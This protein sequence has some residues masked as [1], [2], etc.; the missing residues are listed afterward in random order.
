M[1]PIRIQRERKRG[2]RKPPNTTCVTRGTLWGNPFIVRPDLPVS[3]KVG[4]YFAVPTV[5]DA[6]S[7]YREFL[8]ASPDL[9]EKAKRN[10]FGKN[11]ACWCALDQPCHADVLLELA[12]APEK[13]G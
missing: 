10:L 5:E 4:P 1:K 3:E 8:C 11:L 2:W 7:I 9:V 6:V 13:Q 12:N